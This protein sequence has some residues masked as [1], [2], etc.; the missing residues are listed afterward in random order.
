VK[1]IHISTRDL[2]GGAAR[3]AYRLHSALRI[4]KLDSRMLVADKLSNDPSV[5]AITLPRK[6]IFKQISWRLRWK[7]IHDDLARYQ[8][9]RPPI[10]EYFSDDRSIFGSVPAKR[11]PVCDV[12]N[13]HWVAGFIDYSSFFKLIPKHIPIVWRLSDQ[14]PFTGGCHYDNHCGKFNSGCGACPQLGSNDRSDLSAKIWRRKQQAYSYISSEKMRIVAQSKW[15]KEEIKKSALF[16]RFNA[17]IIPNG[18]DTK[19]FSPCDAGEMR[20]T[21]GISHESKIILF[22]SEAT[23]NLRKGFHLLAE[24]LQEFTAEEKITLLSVGKGKAELKS[25]L[26]YIHLENINDDNRLALIYSMADVL[27]IPSLQDNLPNTALESIA[28]GTPVVGFQVGG[29]PDIVRPGKTGL[30]APLGDVKAFHEAI[31]EILNSD[32]HKQSEMAEKCREIAVREYDLSI[33]T[34][35]YSKLY[36]QI[37]SSSK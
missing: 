30:L 27:V 13:L 7:K 16:G 15:M 5:H 26:S 18:L 20:Q 32:D 22:V 31:R 12:I 33:L 23:T 35:N 34:N 10:Y 9:S 24:A 36:N 6:N 1:I 2:K 28:C 3:S 8:A 4:S 17:E 29:I 11:L 25:P 21:L 37:T 14:N 19:I